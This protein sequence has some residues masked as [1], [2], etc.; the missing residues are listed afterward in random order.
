MIDETRRRGD[1]GTR[2]ENLT[3]IGRWGEGET[4]R[5]LPPFPVSPHLR[6]RFFIG[7]S[8]PAYVSP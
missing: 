1:A 4:W 5:E 6:V 7:S 3:L 2:E 8:T